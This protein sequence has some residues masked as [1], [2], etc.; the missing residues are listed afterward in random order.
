[1]KKDYIETT[2]YLSLLTQ[3][4]LMMAINI[5]VFLLIGLFLDR[6]LQSNGIILILCILVG[7]GSGFYNVYRIVDQTLKDL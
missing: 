3:L 6:W 1:M 7:I 4:G 2:K 5:I